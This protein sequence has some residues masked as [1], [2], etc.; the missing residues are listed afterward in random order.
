MALETVKCEEYQLELSRIMKSKSTTDNG[1]HH[2]A[3]P[4]N[5]LNS[6]IT[7]VSWAPDKDANILQQKVFQ[8]LHVKKILTLNRKHNLYEVYL[9]ENSESPNI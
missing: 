6:S 1:I 7:T 3:L 9:L 5:N 4:S 8:S 2:F